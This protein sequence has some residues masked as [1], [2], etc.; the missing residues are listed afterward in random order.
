MPRQKKVINDYEQFNKIKNYLITGTPVIEV[1][2]KMVYIN[3]KGDK[4]L[5]DTLT[6]SKRIAS[7]DKKPVIGF[8]STDKDESQ[9]FINVKDK[10]TTLKKRS[11]IFKWDIHRKYDNEYSNFKYATQDMKKLISIRNRA[12]NPETIKKYND[13]LADYDKKEQ[14][15]LRFLPGYDY[16]QTQINNYNDAIKYNEKYN[17]NDK[18]TDD[19]FL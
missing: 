18:K 2:P 12:K 10:G 16:E 3:N 1:P 19:F 15:I 7:R 11:D 13:I 5:I 14:N 17:N 4:K 9:T 8:V 6:K